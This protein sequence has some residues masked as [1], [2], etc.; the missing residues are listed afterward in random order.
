MFDRLFQCPA[1]VARHSNAP[2]AEQRRRYLAICEQQGDPTTTLTSKATALFRIARALSVHPDLQ[3][4]TMEQVQAA[5]YKWKQHESSNIGDSDRPPMSPRDVG[6]AT[7]WLQFLRSGPEALDLIPFRAQLD[8]YCR[9]AKEERGF[10]TATVS[11]SHWHMKSFLCWYGTCNRPLMEL[12]ANDIDA[13]L[14]YRSNRGW[15]R[16]T[17]SRVA[18]ILRMFFRYAA[19]QRWTCQDLASVIQAPRI[20]ASETLPAGADW[21]DVRRMFAA[22]DAKNPVDVRDRPI[23][24]LMAIY[25]WRVSEVAALRLE[26]LDWEHDLLRIARRKRRDT[27]I[28]PLLPSLGNAIIQYLKKVRHR[29]SPHREVFLSLHYPFRPISTSSLYNAVADRLAALGVRTAHRGPH[30]LRHACAGR[31]VAE[32]LSLKEIGDHLGHRSTRSTR[33]YAKVDL[34]GLREVAAFD[35]GELL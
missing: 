28:C 34:R 24:M 32:G 27:Q 29:P 26:H 15:C 30:C 16:R 35:L 10:T 7:D 1:T 8:E 2:Y 12:Q 6:L 4:V 23:L 14:T 33:I 31:L 11:Q 5:A 22:L 17:I 25:G 20:Y 21:S 13:Y 18:T 9:W 19:Q 3:Q